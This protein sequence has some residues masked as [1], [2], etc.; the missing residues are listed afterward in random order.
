MAS[1]PVDE[2]RMSYNPFARTRSRE[3]TLDTENPVRRS[4]ALIA[5]PTIEEGRAA[6]KIFGGQEHHNTEPAPAVSN[7]FEPASSDIVTVDAQDGTVVSH[8]NGVTKRAKFKGIFAKDHE[9]G[10]MDSELTRVDE[11]QLSFHERR[12]KA[13]RR[14]IPIW[15]QIRAVLFYNYV[16]TALLPTIPAGFI[17]N[18]LHSHPVAIFCVNLAAIIPSATALS[19]AL[20]DLNIRAGDKLSALLN[21]T[22]G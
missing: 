19:A 1:Q 18:Y 10:Y 2:G 14:K 21:Q 9:N 13:L 15:Q 5:I 16:A 3:S 20:S 8:G 4:E 22:L 6:E 12:E 11:D 17:V 7:G